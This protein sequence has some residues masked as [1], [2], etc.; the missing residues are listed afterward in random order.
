MYSLFI[1]ICLIL[2][3]AWESNLVYF[4]DFTTFISLRYYLDFVSQVCFL[5]SLIQNKTYAAVYLCKQLY[6]NLSSSKEL[7]TAKS[8]IA[9]DFITKMKREHNKT[10]EL[11]KKSCNHLPLHQQYTWTNTNNWKPQSARISPIKQKT[12]VHVLI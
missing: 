12:F 11:L 6:C 4:L 9:S 3:V 10:W 5:Y 7:Y 2:N 8:I 1:K